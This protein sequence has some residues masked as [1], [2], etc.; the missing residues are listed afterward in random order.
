[1]ATIYVNPHIKHAILVEPTRIVG[2]TLQSDGVAI[3]V[4]QPISRMLGGYVAYFS[5]DLPFSVDRGDG[6]EEGHVMVLIQPY[7]QH[8]LRR[9]HGM[10][11]ILIEP[12]SVCPAMMEDPCWTPGTA[13]NA[14]WVETIQRGFEEW[15]RLAVIPDR[16][17][18]Q[19]VFGR[20]LPSRKLDPRIAMAVDILA[21]HPSRLGLSVTVLAQQ[22]GISPS[23]L[24]HLF[25]EE[26]GI[27]IRSFRAWKRIRNSMAV[28]A[29]EPVLLNAALDSGYADEPHYSR[30]M[31]K[32]FGQKAHLMQRHWRGAMTFR[33]NA[34]VAVG[35][36]NAK[37][38]NNL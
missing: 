1:M 36:F 38:L 35:N 14:R 18:D 26:I 6:W 28:A 11:T 20:D 29:S 34:D 10:R 32:Y 15:E 16:S 22:A 19:L 33:V 2:R 13:A 9:C 4:G 27:P 7:Q 8:R 30:S 23:R 17:V 37:V 12:E 31:R 24:S 21:K 5:A 3:E 25:R